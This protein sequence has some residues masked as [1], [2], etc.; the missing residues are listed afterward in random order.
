M[1][2]VCFTPSPITLQGIE[3]TTIRVG[4]YKIKFG[5]GKLSLCAVIELWS[6]RLTLD[7]GSHSPLLAAGIHEHNV[8]TVPST[9][10]SAFADE[11]HHAD[12][13]FNGASPAQF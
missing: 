9:V 11:D 13:S 7:D 10:L 3:S 12:S 6:F 4:K 5:K 2:Y 8:V 1:N